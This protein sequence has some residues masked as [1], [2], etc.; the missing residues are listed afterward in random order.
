VK[1][2]L[3]IVL[4]TSLGVGA[5]TPKIERS[6]RNLITVGPNILVSG[7]KPTN[8]HVEPFVVSDPKDP[9][10]LLAASIAY[11]KADGTSTCVVFT[12]FDGGQRWTRTQLPTLDSMER[13]VD[14]WT[15]FGP[16]SR[17][18]FC[19]LTSVREGAKEHDAILVYVS[20]DGG[21]TW[22][23]PLRLPLG[24][25]GSYDH[26]TITVDRTGSAFSGRVYVSA[27]QNIRVPLV[28]GA[29]RIVA[30]RS[31]DGGSS[32]AD[33]IQ[34]HPNDFWHQDGNMTVL[35]DGTVIAPFFEVSINE[36]MLG[37][38]RVWLVRSSDGGQ[39]FSTPYFVTELDGTGSFLRMAADES[40]GEYR[41]HLYMVRHVQAI[42]GKH[43]HI[44]L[45]SSSNKGATWE[46]VV[47]FN[48]GLGT[49]IEQWHPVV[50]VNKEGIV[51][52]AWK[53]TR[54]DQAKKYWDV[55]FTASLDGAKTFM[56]RVR[57]TSIRSC[58]NTPGNNIPAFPG[59]GTMT[60]SQRWITGGDYNG[61][62][63]SSDGLFHLMWAD[64]RTGVYQ[65][66]TSS[67]KVARE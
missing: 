20:V 53:Q 30:F 55:I 63:A 16:D 59:L 17:A 44:S 9:R 51:G 42:N 65:I 64:S 10:H 26:P 60:I 8:P 57:V 43:S 19:C 62:T 31:T 39:S 23:K 56:P 2:G 18:Y 52:V 38:S 41:D 25:G 32:F 7:D 15:A 1:R 13:A 46:H 24:D 67:I 6:R 50:A 21:R 11:T 27:A 29:S 35:S 40:S 14:P 37:H 34:I 49:R 48:A 3:L 58:P 61:L 12:S 5:Y 4:L 28:K 33:P 54:K 66:W 36:V 47:D 22:S 45:W